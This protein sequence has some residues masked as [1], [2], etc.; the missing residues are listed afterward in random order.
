[1]AAIVQG[2]KYIKYLNVKAKAIS[3]GVPSTMESNEFGSLAVFHINA[4]SLEA[5][6]ISAKYNKISEIGTF[7]WEIE[8]LKHRA[9]P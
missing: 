1:M 4:L 7:L 8:L 9:F 3:F 5:E 2:L 6:K